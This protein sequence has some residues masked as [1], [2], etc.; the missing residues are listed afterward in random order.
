MQSKHIYFDVSFLFMVFAFSF[1]SVIF[2]LVVFI[3]IITVNEIPDKKLLW[4]ISVIWT[5][6]IT[7]SWKAKK[8]VTI[9]RKRLQLHFFYFYFFFFL[10]LANIDSSVIAGEMKLF[11]L[12][13]LTICLAKT[14]KKDFSLDFPVSFFFCYYCFVFHLAVT[15]CTYVRFNLS[16]FP[17]KKFLCCFDYR[18]PL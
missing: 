2:L 10:L 11:F 18:F 9:R 1:T 4:W 6:N 15:N 13:R 8:K 7:D 12:R 14:V 16:L 5:A 17:N 3:T